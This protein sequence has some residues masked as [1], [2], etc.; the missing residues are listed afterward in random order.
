MRTLF[1][2]DDSAQGLSHGTGSV[3]EALFGKRCDALIAFI[4]RVDLQPQRLLI[5]LLELAKEDAERLIARQRIL[6]QIITT[7]LGGGFR[8]AGA[9]ITFAGDKISFVD[10]GRG[11]GYANSRLGLYLP[12]ESPDDRPSRLS[13]SAQRLP[14][15]MSEWAPRILSRASQ[16]FDD[17]AAATYALRLTKTRMRD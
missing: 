12:N 17:I 16:E 9:H 11:D 14:S 15:S 3:S 2:D 7:S 5:F 8:R 10:F 4:G 1:I 13:L 6:A